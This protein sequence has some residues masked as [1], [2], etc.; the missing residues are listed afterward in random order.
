[1]RK[2]VAW[3]VLAA[4]LVSLTACGRKKPEEDP[5]PAGSY[6]YKKYRY[7]EG[8]EKEKVL[9]EEYENLVTEATRNTYDEFG[10]LRSSCRE[11]FDETGEHL[12]KDVYREVGLT[13]VTK[14]YDTLGRCISETIAF[15]EEADAD[16][17]ALGL[18]MPVFYLLY[19]SKS[20]V[21]I[22]VYSVYGDFRFRLVTGRDTG[23]EVKELRTT[24]SYRGDTVEIIGAHSTTDQGVTV[25]DLE[26][27]D[28][29][30]AL[31][32]SLLTGDLQ[33]E[34]VYDPSENKAS[35]HGTTEDVEF[36]G[37]KEY[38]SEGRCERI[39]FNSREYMPFFAEEREYGYRYET[40]FLYNED[41]YQKEEAEYVTNGDENLE[42]H[43]LNR[44]KYNRDGAMILNEGYAED[45]NDVQQLRSQS[46]LEYTEDGNLLR[47][48][49]RFCWENS[50]YERRE[51]I[52][53]TDRGFIS[54]ICE[55]TNDHKTFITSDI[56]EEVRVEHLDD[57]EKKG[58]H[59]HI[60]LYREDDAIEAYAVAVP[61][62]YNLP[63]EDFG[64]V[65][66]SFASWVLYSNFFEGKKWMLYSC[67]ISNGGLNVKTISSEFDEDGRLREVEWQADY[68]GANRDNSDSVFHDEY[69]EQ[70]RLCRSRE[71]MKSVNKAIITEWEYFDRR[72]K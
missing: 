55:E 61:N 59:L 37:V 8:K 70:G 33:Y 9:L 2:T 6:G 24:Y 67:V 20:L 41:G 30:I 63:D 16:T 47:W 26:M 23:P 50:Y 34:E 28:G 32:E 64:A 68:D 51:E 65:G 71:L 46:I 15:D 44:S 69:D 25:G 1:M 11:Y 38:D 57:P 56:S 35:F 7:Y 21:G 5:R 60:T 36:Q 54:R 4:L 27:G 49:S 17:I 52:E 40:T 3:I 39:E 45:E 58:E 66:D 14:E 43:L 18:E 12:L 22:P 48:I 10:E 62:E 31:K 42:R 13:V 72:D 29:D 19:C 53:Y